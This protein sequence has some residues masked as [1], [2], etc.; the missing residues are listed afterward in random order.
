MSCFG[1]PNSRKQTVMKQLTVIPPSATLPLCLADA[2][3]TQTLAFAEM[4]KSAGTRRA[5]GSDWLIFTAWCAERDLES[6]PASPGTAA[7][8]LSSQAT[9]AKKSSTIGRR[10]AAIA[11]A[12]KLAGYEPPTNAE[13]VKAVVRGIRRAI[14][15][16]PVRK[17]PVTADLVTQMIEHCDDSLIG[18][19]DR[20]LL[21]F[22]F[23]GAFRR[24]ELV[25]LEVSELLATADGFRVT[26]RRSKTD[27]EGE[28]QE[29][30]I[31][32]GCRIEPVKA[33]EAWLAAS[34]ITAG[35]VFRPIAKGG[36]VQDMPLSGHSAAAI[37]KRYATMAGL[38]ASTFAGHSLRAGF[39]T[40]AAEAGSSVLKMVEVSR[41]K[42]IDMLTTYVRRSNL[43]R[44]HAGAAFL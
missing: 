11:Y 37:V 26:I 41:H 22:G 35:P 18:L 25:A 7:R 33:I 2:E 44:E 4:E 36:R 8:F 20:A 31:P 10:A 6:L 3:M 24:S 27:Q 28:G 5:Y 32:R 9:D 34:G 42:S 13:T 30:A 39:L 14:G 43:F 1:K 17:A 19:R 40:S 12:H 38:D 23:A 21:A 15:T 16:A 29:I